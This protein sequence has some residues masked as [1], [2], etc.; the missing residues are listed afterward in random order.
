MQ[1]VKKIPGNIPGILHKTA[2]NK[3]TV[4]AMR[5]THMSALTSAGIWVLLQ[6]KSVIIQCAA[7]PIPAGLK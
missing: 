5:F 2:G 1:I 7:V 6:K 3:M 4:I